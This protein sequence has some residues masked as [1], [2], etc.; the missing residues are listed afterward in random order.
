MN[1]HLPWVVECGKTCKLKLQFLPFVCYFVCRVC[2]FS[3]FLLSPDTFSTLGIFASEMCVDCASRTL[4][5]FS[6]NTNIFAIR[7]FRMQTT[8]CSSQK[9][10][11]KKGKE[12]MKLRLYCQLGAT[13]LFN[14]DECIVFL[15]HNNGKAWHWHLPLTKSAAFCCLCALPR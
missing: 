15:E 14:F 2:V 10:W 3:C 4:L 5:L 11:T 9:K 8:K 13:N 6:A 7:S 1:S 12:Q